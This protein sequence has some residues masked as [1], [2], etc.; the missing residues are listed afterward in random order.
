MYSV[1]D[2]W[3]QTTGDGLLSRNIPVLAPKWLNY[4]V[5]A[6]RR[7]DD[8]IKWKRFPRYWPFVR[9]IHRG[10]V[11]SPHKGQWHGALMFSL[12]CARINGWV[13]N[14][15]AGDLRRH[16]A[17]CDVIVMVQK[18]M[19]VYRGAP[20]DTND[21]I[22]PWIFQ[23]TAAKQSKCESRTKH[24]VKWTHFRHILTINS[25]HCATPEDMLN[26][27]N[28]EIF[29]DIKS[30]QKCRWKSVKKAGFQ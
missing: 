25:Q 13:N 21:Q 5:F 8:V 2:L 7:Y 14:R 24:S 30:V 9:R 20:M 28:I 4:K 16:Q 10:P 1:H 12:I 3:A 19:F 29:K 17:H 26:I 22:L 11:N 27:Y 18:C 15:E 6:F 23:I